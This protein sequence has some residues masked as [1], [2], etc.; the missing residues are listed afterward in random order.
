MNGEA[1]APLAQLLERELARLMAQSMARTG[2]EVLTSQDLA[3]MLDVEVA[4]QAAG[5]EVD[6]ACLA[7]IAGSLG[8]DL[9]L[10]SS[11]YVI[12]GQR[13]LDLTLTD[14]SAARVQGRSAARGNDATALERALPDAV[15]ALWSKDA[16]GVVTDGTQ[17]GSAA[18]P[19]L[20]VTGSVLT[21]V[22][23]IGVVVA[24][25][26]YG[27]AVSTGATLAS[28]EAALVSDPA[29]GDRVDDLKAAHNANA[30]AVEGWNTL[31]VTLGAVGGALVVAGVATAISAAFVG[32]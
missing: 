2:G 6:E 10:T 22:G 14:R 26:L 20:V 19:M 1:N 9:V 27:G 31:G 4:R 29:D 3:A 18:G 23:V 12:D 11:L 30:A 15:A 32:E 13:R 28:A 5:C 16:D 24:G 25:L 17:E 21:A 7:E 8:A